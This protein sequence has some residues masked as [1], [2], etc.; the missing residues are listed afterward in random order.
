MPYVGFG[1]HFVIALY[2]AVHAVRSGQD[3]YWLMVLFMFPLLGSVVYAVAIWLPAARHDPRGR[4]LVRGVRAKLDPHRELRQAQDAFDGS[5][6]TSNRLRLADALLEAGR[7]GDAV[8]HFHASLRGIHSD[9]AD[10]QVRLAQALLES[11]QAGAARELLDAVIQRNPDFRSEHGH[12]VYARAVDAEGNR[13]K[14]R[15]EFETLVGYSTSYEVKAAYAEALHGWGEHARAVELCGEAL[16]Q[17]R[18]LPGYSRKLNAG[19]I[20]RIKRVSALLAKAR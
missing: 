15:E 16:T 2:F 1:L 3:R 10:I 14:A 9:D 19:A 18:R 20:D 12:L 13:A 17:A 11:G 5:A 6:S 4:K 8:E 7:A